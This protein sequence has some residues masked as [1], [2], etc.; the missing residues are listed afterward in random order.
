[1]LFLGVEAGCPAFRNPRAVLDVPIGKTTRVGDSSPE[2][3]ELITSNFNA[4]KY[5]PVYSVKRT[6]EKS[7][8]EAEMMQYVAY[9]RVS[10]NKQGITGF[11][12][13]AQREAVTR[14]MAGK[15]SSW[16]SLSKWKPAR[17]ASRPQL[18]AALAECRKRRAVLVIA[19][20]DRL[21]AT[22]ISF[23]A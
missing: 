14:F 4:L 7:T 15:G 12:M 3:G 19:K 16:P 13:D 20:L 17:K 22:S 2:T 18:T 8:V 6:F 5:F 9:Y 11:G 1:M 23:P 21:P 10:T